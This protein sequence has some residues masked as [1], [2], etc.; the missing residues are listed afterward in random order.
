VD[1]RTT[2]QEGDHAS[3][4]NKPWTSALSELVDEARSEVVGCG[5]AG[6][7]DCVEAHHQAASAGGRNTRSV[8]QDQLGDQG[9]WVGGF[10]IFIG[11]DSIGSR[12]S[13]GVELPDRHS[14]RDLLSVRT[15]QR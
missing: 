8:E 2:H 12:P 6:E 13:Q 3:A 7:F 11:L 4:A 9:A 15:Q 14:L 5:Q 10:Q 1:K